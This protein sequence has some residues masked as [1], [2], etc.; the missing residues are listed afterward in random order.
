MVILYSTHCPMCMMVEQR[1]K[2]KNI[3]YQEVTDENEIIKLGFQHVPLLKIGDNIY[4][5]TKDILSAIN[6]L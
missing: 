5:N 4:S 6:S 2:A 1:L 3:P